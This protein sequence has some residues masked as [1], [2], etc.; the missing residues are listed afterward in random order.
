MKNVKQKISCLK[1]FIARNPEGYKW[2]ME[3]YK[4]YK[5]KVKKQDG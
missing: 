3:Q 2:L 5:N 1:G 4:P